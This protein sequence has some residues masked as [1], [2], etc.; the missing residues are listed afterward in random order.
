MTASEF[1]GAEITLAKDNLLDSNVSHDT[2]TFNGALQSQWE[3]IRDGMAQ[4]AS[5]RVQQMKDNPL[6]T[7]VETASSFGL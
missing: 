2:H 4:G 5:A 3:V 1:H 7:G 6:A